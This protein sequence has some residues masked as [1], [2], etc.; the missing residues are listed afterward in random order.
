MNVFLITFRRSSRPARIGSGSLFHL[1]VR[2][3][4]ARRS[5]GDLRAEYIC[6]LRNPLFVHGFIVAISF[7]YIYVTFC[8]SNLN[9][10]LRNRTVVNAPTNYLP[11]LLFPL[12]LSTR[13]YGSLD[14]CRA[15]RFDFI[16]DYITGTVIQN[17][18]PEYLPHPG[19]TWY[20]YLCINQFTLANLKRRVPEID[21]VTHLRRG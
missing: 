4:H 16:S 15:L 5:I 19:W 12:S 8:R 11:D 21:P 18:Y 7:W 3:L 13:H 10:I 6:L 1:R 2:Y 17:L 9:Q 14:D 20:T